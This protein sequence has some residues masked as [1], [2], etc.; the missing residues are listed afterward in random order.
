MIHCLEYTLGCRCG[1]VTIF[2][3]EEPRKPNG[4][5]RRYTGQSEK[6]SYFSSWLPAP[7][8]MVLDPTPIVL[9]G[10]PQNKMVA[11]IATEDFAG[12]LFFEPNHV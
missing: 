2:G 9:I 6:D 10:S 4:Y 8:H 7:Y 5:G 11:S 3:S 1:W 12:Q